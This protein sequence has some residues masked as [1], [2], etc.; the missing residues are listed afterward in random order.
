MVKTTLQ[1]PE[2][3]WRAAKIRAMDEHTDLRTLLIRGLE[4]VLA[5]KPKKG[6]A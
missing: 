3:L 1:L 2:A 4:R 5:E 6:G